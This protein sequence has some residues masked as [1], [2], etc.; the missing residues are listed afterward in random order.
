MGGAASM[1]RCPSCGRLQEAQL[2]CA[3]CGAPLASNLDYFAALALPH[4]LQIDTAKLQETYH[5]LGR[6]IHPDRFAAS[7]I[8]LKDASMRAT[9]LLTRAYRTLREP[10]SR[11]LYWLELNGRKLSDNNQQVPADLAATVFE[12]Q[13]QLAELRAARAEDAESAQS[14][15]AEVTAQRDQLREAMSALE[16]ELANNFARW[17]AANGH[18]HEALF[19]ELKTTLSKLAY[20]RTLLRDV[21]KELDAVRAA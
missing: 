3:E 16:H 14:M 19:A 21:E 18:D 17:D 10:V 7:S 2:V 8:K 9:A 4:K 13:E 12:V 1:V 15:R 5:Q 20:M 6:R 11:G